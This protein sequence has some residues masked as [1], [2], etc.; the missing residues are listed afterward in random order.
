M[1]TVWNKPSIWIIYL[2]YE[3]SR[4]R[5]IQKKKKKKLN[6]GLVFLDLTKAFNTVN[7]SILLYKREHYGIRVIV[8][9]T[10]GSLVLF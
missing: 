3:Y 6:I 5:H 7:H 4:I 9:N 1:I 8:N 2:S 10:F